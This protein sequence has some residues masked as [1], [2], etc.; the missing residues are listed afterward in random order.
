MKKDFLNESI[1]LEIYN[2]K[3]PEER[4]EQTPFDE[5]RFFLHHLKNFLRPYSESEINCAGKLEQIVKRWF[6][7]FVETLD[8]NR[9]DTIKRVVQKCDNDDFDLT[10]GYPNCNISIEYSPDELLDVGFC[11]SIVEPTKLICID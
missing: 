8:Q 9:K 2:N 6:K 10:V 7:D 5:I 11:G 4:R 1:I 3:M